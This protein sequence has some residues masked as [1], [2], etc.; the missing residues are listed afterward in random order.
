MRDK[1]LKVVRFLYF[2]AII[3]II[4]GCSMMGNNDQIMRAPD[5]LLS[6]K[7]EM[8]QLAAKQVTYQTPQATFG[9]YTVELQNAYGVKQRAKFELRQGM[10]LQD[11][12]RESKAMDQFNF[13]TIKLRRP[14]ADPMRFLP[15]EIEFNPEFRRIEPIND[16]AI[17]DG[18]YIIVRQQATGE[19][20]EMFGNLKSQAGL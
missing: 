13:M 18:D 6:E 15:L 14:T 8:M 10:F 19:L 1:S 3:C 11:A 20:D 7:T 12:L 9:H 16:Y 2:A 17:H 5:E 4:S